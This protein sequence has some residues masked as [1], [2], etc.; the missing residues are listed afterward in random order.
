VS[1]RESDAIN[2]LSIIGFWRRCGL[3]APRGRKSGA[4]LRGPLA[5]KQ[6]RA[7]RL[8][9]IEATPHSER[10]RLIREGVRSY[11][12]NGSLLHR[13]GDGMGKRDWVKSAGKKLPDDM[14]DCPTLPQE[15]L[16]VLTN[17][18]DEKR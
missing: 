13:M 15:M 18:R 3:R 7:R 9:L 1:R 14:G 12:R 16:D 2:M 17:L 10:R 11:S 5:A 4:T 6:M 8:A